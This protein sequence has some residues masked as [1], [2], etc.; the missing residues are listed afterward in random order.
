LHLAGVAHRLS[1]YQV[2]QGHDRDLQRL[3]LFAFG[4]VQ[5]NLL[6]VVA[7]GLSEGGEALLL[8]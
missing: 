3:V 6:D 7:V 1:T 2:V 5:L 4:E 8:L